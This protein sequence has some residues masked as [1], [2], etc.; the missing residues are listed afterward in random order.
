[1]IGEVDNIR[2]ELFSIERKAQEIPPVFNYDT[3]NEDVIERDSE[4]GKF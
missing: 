3:E 4:R 1:M 2:F